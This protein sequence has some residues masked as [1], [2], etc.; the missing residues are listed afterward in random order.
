MTLIEQG[1]KSAADNKRM[2]ASGG[3]SY[4]ESHELHHKKV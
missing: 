2:Y 4:R 3:M 1:M